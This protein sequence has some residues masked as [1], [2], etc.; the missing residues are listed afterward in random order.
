LRGS[1]KIVTAGTFSRIWCQTARKA[2]SFDSFTQWGYAM[3]ESEISQL[4]DLKDGGNSL[5]QLAT[6]LFPG[7]RF[8]AT[9]HGRYVSR[10]A[11]FVT[12]KVHSQR[13]R[14]ITLTL[15]GY[16]NEFPKSNDLL[17]RPDRTGYSAIK[18]THAGQ[19]NSAARCVRR[20]AEIFSQR[21]GWRSDVFRR[22]LS[23]A[24]PIHPHPTC[25]ILEKQ[26]PH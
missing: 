1:K 23:T 18:I 26:P 25:G 13:A 11:N 10:P 16:P 21:G 15:R 9:A 5:V 17:V 19:F 8:E 24:Y 20:A 14:N 12:F 6:S 2:G 3:L 4:P 22:P 7:L